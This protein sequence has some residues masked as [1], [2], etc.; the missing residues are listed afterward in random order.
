MSKLDKEKEDPVQD[1]KD[2]ME[3]C[4]TFSPP[5]EA[6][7]MVFV[8]M[9]RAGKSVLVKS[10]MHYYDQQHYFAYGICISG[11]AFNGDYDYLPSKA[12]WAGWDEERLKQ[13]IKVLELRAYELKKQKK[14]LPPSFIIFDDL[15]GELSNS[16]FVRN[17]FS[18][19]R[20]YNLTL[21]SCMQ[22]PTGQHCST[23]FRS[24]VDYAF[25]FPS[26]MQ[27]VCDALQASWGPHFKNGNEMKDVLMEIK[28]T[29][30]T[31]LLYRKDFNTKEACNRSFRCT[32]APDKFKMKFGKKKDN[33][34]HKILTDTNV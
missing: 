1:E 17:L 18:I 22:T 33:D 4:K 20:H 3:D 11:S 21:M 24:L 16:N 5:L 34:E 32:P 23:V 27:S 30:Y 6:S 8:G 7:V 13:Y 12:L 25:M 26:S 19:F 28:K 31:C 2:E 29:K 9:P 14:K 10:I 15:L